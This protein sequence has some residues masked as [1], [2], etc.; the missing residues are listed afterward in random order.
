MDDFD[1]I[2]SLQVAPLVPL[3]EGPDVLPHQFEDTIYIAVLSIE[4]IA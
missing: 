2:T 1:R 3:G 4:T